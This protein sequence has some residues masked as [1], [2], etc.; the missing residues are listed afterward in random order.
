MK[1]ISNAHNSNSFN[2][3]I[4]RFDDLISLKDDILIISGG[5]GTHI[6]EYLKIN[7]FEDANKKIDKFRE[8]FGDDFILE[9]QRT[10]RSDELEY[11]KNILPISYE[12]NIPLIATND[13]LF[14]NQDDYDTHE[15]KVCINTGKTLNDPNREKLFSDQ[16]YFKSSKEMSLLFSDYP[17][18]VENTNEIS[19]KCNVSLNT[20]G[21]FLPEYPVPKEHDFDSFIKNYHL[22]D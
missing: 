5:R 2:A 20:K 7:N 10:K 17:S 8:S 22:T 11:F 19:K 21:Y 16:Q 18:L 12:K 15:T 1:I 9:V 14:S 3:P 6:F 13:V 4:I